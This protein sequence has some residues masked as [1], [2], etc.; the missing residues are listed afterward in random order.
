[1]ASSSA[2]ISGD[3]ETK[4]A[5]LVKR[6]C[7]ILAIVGSTPSSNSSLVQIL[8]YGFL[9]TTKSWLDEILNGSIGEFVALPFLNCRYDDYSTTNWR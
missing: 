8:R 9:K 5:A 4:K 7:I 1:M 6:R 3:N 2:T